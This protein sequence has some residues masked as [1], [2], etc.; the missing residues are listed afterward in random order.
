MLTDGLSEVVNGPAGEDLARAAAGAESIRSVADALLV[1]PLDRGVVG[2]ALSVLGG[3]VAASALDA[4][5]RV[6]GLGA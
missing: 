1:C 2:R 3:D 6:L 5:E 4:Y